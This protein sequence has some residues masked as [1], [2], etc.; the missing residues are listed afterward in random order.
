M[1]QKKET[2]VN[3]TDDR[4]SE[5]VKITHLTQIL[6]VENSKNGAQVKFELIPRH[7]KKMPIH[8]FKKSN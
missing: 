5:Y 3:N 2:K 7:G 1:S 6:E 4:S 8:R